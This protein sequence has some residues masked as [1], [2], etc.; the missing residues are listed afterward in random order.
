MI[1]Y[2]TALAQK[3]PMLSV[4]PTFAKDATMTASHVNPMEHALHAM[5]MLTSE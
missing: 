2:V 1:S 5:V 3:D 4:M